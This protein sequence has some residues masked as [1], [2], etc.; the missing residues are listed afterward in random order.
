MW[1]TKVK[2]V[3]LNI[4]GESVQ[5]N[6][7]D[8]ENRKNIKNLELP[9]NFEFDSYW[10]LTHNCLKCNESIQ[11]GTKSDNNTKS[12]FVQ[13]ETLKPFISRYY[14]VGYLI[15]IP[16]ILSHTKIIKNEKT[17][18][19]VV[20]NDS[21]V[22]LTNEIIDVPIVKVFI[23]KCSSCRSDYM[24]RYTLSVGSVYEKDS[25]DSYL[26]SMSVFEIVKFDLDELQA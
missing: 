24:A 18:W 9:I 8:I 21:Y 10:T 26:N 20:T 14:D 25:R 5:K 7:E 4:F 6:L 11:F 19:F 12:N 2:F 23:Y 22:D 15:K 3:D 16:K 1:S 13:K 17:K